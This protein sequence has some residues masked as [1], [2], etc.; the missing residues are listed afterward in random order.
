MSKLPLNRALRSTA[1]MDA[2]L[3]A[4]ALAYLIIGRD[5]V[6]HP[7]LYA[8]TVAVY[9]GLIL[10]LRYA[11]ALAVRPR[12][13]LVLECAA[14]VGFVTGVL[15][16]A[17]GEPGPLLNLYL[18]PIVTAALALGR[19][20]L[21]F[22]VVMVLAARVGLAHFIE[23]QSV[24]T[25]AYGLMLLAEAIPVLLVASL[26]AALSADLREADQRLR[27]MSDQDDLTGVLKLEA[28]TRALDD[29]LA[30]SAAR[31][32]NFALLMV[33]I[34]DL[35][36]LNDRH[37]PEAGSK[38]LEA[39]AQALKRSS[40]SVDIVARYG[41]D[42]FVML[43]SGAGPAVA[44]AVANRVRHN[45]GTTTVDLGGRLHRLAVNIG[46]AVFPADGRQPR[47]LIARA[48]QAMEKD[49]DSRRPL[50]LLQQASGEV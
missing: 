27:A 22:V 40:R 1:R 11:P 35:K 6:A 48:G 9:G 19:V 10:L 47:D 42:E 18:L 45:V 7:G 12:E 32:S 41:G 8:L 31:G 49:K 24:L 36:S 30:R 38:A 21:T 3:L 33:D 28:F 14:M 4:L 44:K 15:A 17:G 34:D 25:F 43:L 13:K 16:L 23:G 2:L 46:A 37:G 5:T 26:T 29:E 20:A 50:A 39:L